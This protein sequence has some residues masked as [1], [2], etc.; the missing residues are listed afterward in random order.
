MP[1]LIAYNLTTE[2]AEKV[3]DL[4]GSMDKRCTES[5]FGDYGYSV[6]DEVPH[7]ISIVN[8]MIEEE[9]PNTETIDVNTLTHQSQSCN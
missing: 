4:V 9:M 5:V 3:M 7:I 1:N 8:S 6:I 2:E